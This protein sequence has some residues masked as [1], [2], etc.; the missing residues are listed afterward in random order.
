VLISLLNNNKL[1]RNVKSQI[2]AFIIVGILIIAIVWGVIIVSDYFSEQKLE[3]VSET[4][5]Q[6]QLESET[7]KSHIDSCVERSTDNSIQLIVKQGLHLDIPEKVL[8]K[9]DLSYWMIDTA[10]VMPSSL[11]KIEQDLSN[12]INKEILNCVSFE[13]FIK[14]G[15]SISNFQPVTTFTI[16]EESIGTEVKYKL[17]VKR[18]KFER[19]FSDS[20]YSQNIRLKRMYEKSLDLVNTQLLSPM[21]DINNPLEGYDNT[22]Y[23]INKQTLDNKTILFQ[24]SDPTSKLIN[25]ETLTLKFVT[26]FGTNKNY[27]RSYDVTN[28]LSDR[29]IYSP[30]RLAMVV[31]PS[32]IRSTSNIITISQYQQ[33]YVTRYNIPTGKLNENYYGYHDVKIKTKYPTY[34]FTPDGTEF[35]QPAILSILLNKDQVEGS[36]DFSLFYSKNKWLPY[37]NEINQEEG[38][39]STLVGGFS[40]YVAVDCEELETETAEAAAEVDQSFLMAYLPLILAVIAAWAIWAAPWGWGGSAFVSGMQGTVLPFITGALYIGVS[41]AV[42]YMI[43]EAIVGEIEDDKTIIFMGKCQDQVT[44]TKDESGGDGICILTDVTAGE[45]KVVDGTPVF[46]KPGHIYSL[47]G[48]IEIGSFET[49]GEC[50]CSTSGLITVDT[51]WTHPK[52]PVEEVEEPDYLICCISNEGYCLENYL[53]DECIGKKINQTCG[54]ITECAGEPPLSG[55]GTLQITLD[56]APVTYGIQGDEFLVTYYVPSATSTTEVI[57]HVKVDGTEVEELELFD[58]GNYNDGDPNDLYFANTWDSKNKLPYLKSSDVTWDIEVIYGNI[59]SAKKYGV[60]SIFLIDN[61]LDCEPLIPF[62]KDKQ[63]DIVFASNHY[64]NADEYTTATNAIL[65]KIAS[66][67]PFQGHLENQEINFFKLKRSF[68]TESLSQIK[69]YS[70]ENCDFNEPAQ[71]LTISINEQAT[72]C[73]QDGYIVEINP[74]FSFKEGTGS[75]S[76]SSVLTNFCDYINEINLLNPPLVEILTEN[77]TT[78]PSQITVDFQITDEEY[79]VEYELIWNHVTLVSSKVLN[80][81][82][83]S[84]VLD[85]SN[86]NWFVQIKATDQRGSVG[87]SNILGI[88]MDNTLKVNFSSIQTVNIESG[89]ST[90]INLNDYVHDPMSGS[91]AEWTHD[92]GFSECVNFDPLIIKEGLVILK[93]IKGESCQ[94]TVK[95]EAVTSDDRRGSDSI[96]IRAG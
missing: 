88:K 92:P 47:R 57:A 46:V 50:K 83:K 96:V 16:Q 45:S 39:I 38:R 56:G 43:G 89:G 1:K 34:R 79:P 65:S 12:Y 93:H 69:S 68:A 32:G 36:E 91:I 9:E 33:D 31:I 22:G 78:I 73:K 7:I 90:T 28:Y 62:S 35:D 86:G 64:I 18:E 60:G 21:L 76:M 82:I 20:I 48:E 80:N 54:E 95:F 58:D 2:T 30:D 14:N 63:V 67:Q 49:E 41:A 81:S 17:K 23:T 53:S 75:A 42:G 13:K 72:S 74:L 66:I 8:Y 84:H 70:G 52:E 87:Y 4:E 37:P 51:S 24:I 25:G 15:W 40:E 61:S 85:L 19:G 71:R 55:E 59:T 26:S 3:G 27:S 44:I 29:I 10:N 5:Q 11:E 94:E 6:I 77:I